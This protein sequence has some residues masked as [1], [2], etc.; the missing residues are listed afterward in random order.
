M[1]R[2]RLEIKQESLHQEWKVRHEKLTQ[3]RQKLATH[4]DTS[5]KIQ[6]EK[7]IQDEECEISK[8]EERLE[9]IE[10]HLDSLN[11]Q[12][13]NQ[14]LPLPQLS[15]VQVSSLSSPVPEYEYQYRILDYRNL[16]DLIYAEKWREANKETWEL[17]LKVTNRER[18]GWIDSDSFKIFS[19]K[20][21][22]IIDR[23]WINGSEGHFGFSVQMKIWEEF[24]CP[25]ANNDN[26]P[27]F[28]DRIGWCDEGKHWPNPKFNLAISPLGELPLSID[29]ASY[30]AWDASGQRLWDGVSFFQRIL[31]CSKL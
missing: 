21:L 19:C 6:L 23:L 31:N 24:G 7:E 18:H 8:L 13:S 17:M 16:R 27:R 3:L 12:T 1:K 9:E 28:L 22:L 10:Q 11:S 14:A 29:V 20:D 4:A 5:V 2:Q 25:M 26:W 30:R 15:N